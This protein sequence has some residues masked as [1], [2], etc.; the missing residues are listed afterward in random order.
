MDYP[1]DSSDKDLDPEIALKRALEEVEDRR[2]SRNCAR[3]DSV[4]I[5]LSSEQAEVAR[6]Y[7]SSS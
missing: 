4:S 1:S 5:L 3:T 6:M 7:Y 2:Q